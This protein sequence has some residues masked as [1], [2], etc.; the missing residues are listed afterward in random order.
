MA[1]GGQREAQRWKQLP[2]ALRDLGT[3]PVQGGIGD[4]RHRRQVG[5]RRTLG[6]QHRKEAQDSEGPGQHHAETRRHLQPGKLV[7]G[8]CQ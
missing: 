8:G 1:S 5:A 2:T 3:H 4:G 6:V 7:A